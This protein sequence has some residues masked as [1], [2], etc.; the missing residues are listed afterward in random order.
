MSEL[1]RIEPRSRCKQP[2]NPHQSLAYALPTVTV[3]FLYSPIAFIQG[4]YAKY[5]GL[6]LTTIAGI[7]LLARLFDAVTDPVVGYFSDRYYARKGNRKIFVLGG[8]LLFVCCSYF[9]YIP[10][11]INA[12]APYTPISSWYFLVSLT[13][14]YLAWTIFEI[15]HLAWG[16]ELATSNQNRTAIFSLRALGVF[17]GYL[18]FYAIPFL[19]IFD[20]KGFTPQTLIWLVLMGAI[21]MPL[22]LYYSIKTVPAQK[23]GHEPQNLS[24]GKPVVK[25]NLYVLWPILTNNKPLLLFLAAFFF[26]GAG[27]GMTSGMMYIFADSYLGLGEHLPLVY[28]LCMFI[29]TLSIWGW[30]NLA[31]VFSKIIAW[32]LGA[33]III[34]GVLATHLLVPGESG[35]LS[36]LFVSSLLSIGS[37]ANIVLAPALLSDIIDYGT[38][39]F[40][41]DYAGTYF[42]LYTLI[43]KANFAIGG[44]ISLG[45]AG[46]FGFDATAL[47]HSLGQIFGLH[48]GLVYIPAFT[49]S[50]SLIF[51]I[52]TPLTNRRY[53]VI[54]RR[55]DGREARS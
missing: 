22:I 17:L 38:W 41:Q 23:S 48:L 28:F 11:G 46:A 50:V 49:V 14:F 40:G 15:P 19:P 20:N 3:A 47:N 21:L 2:L 37:A 1:S 39:K 10:A 26:S 53:Q 7:L 54:R 44:A 4:I 52:L 27:A 43:T 24:I 36:L 8:G 33:V 55:S 30:N 34:I 31:T 5:F 51:I 32:G 42:S 16:C 6:S 29:G 13:L 25:T 18:L 9:L 12:T 35:W 45:V